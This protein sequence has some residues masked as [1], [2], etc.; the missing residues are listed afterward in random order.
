MSFLTLR[1]RVFA[2][3]WKASEENL[4]RQRKEAAARINTFNRLPLW[5]RLI[6]LI[7]GIGVSANRLYGFERFNLQSL[8][9]FPKTWRVE[10]PPYVR[11][12]RRLP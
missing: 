9:S 11:D 12:L 7:R 1:D 8:G 5:H 3:K 6:M 2:E 10:C 4:E